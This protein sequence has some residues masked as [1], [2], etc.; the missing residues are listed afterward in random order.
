[1]KIETAFEQNKRVTNIVAIK[2]TIKEVKQEVKE[3]TSKVSSRIS[4][5]TKEV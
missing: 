2:E 3:V 5:N 1:M 4:K